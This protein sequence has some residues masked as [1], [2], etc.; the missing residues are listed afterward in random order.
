MADLSGTE[1]GGCRLIR[2]IGI[3]GMGEVYLGEQMR[4]GNRP[5][6]IK[7]VR[8]DDPTLTAD[9]IKEIERRFTREAALLGSF[10][11]PNILPV[12]DAG[13][14][15]RLLYLVMDYVEDGSLA[16][17]IRPGP[18]QKLAP[19]VPAPLTAE[20]IGQVAA[21]LQYTHDRGVVH[22]DVKP[23]NI[24]A[25]R[26]SD[27][28]WQL[29]LA[30]FGIAKAMQ[31]A[32]QK[33]QVTGTLTYMAP[34]QFSGQFSPASDQY[35][36]G[37]VAY[38]LLAGRPPFE[39]DLA[40]MTQAHLNQ[41]PPP[42]SRFNPGISP[43]VEAVVM[44]ALAKSPAQRFSRVADFA[45]ALRDA[46]TMPA[47]VAVGGTADAVRD[48]IGAE[49]RRPGLAR[50]WMAVLAALLLLAGGLGGAGVLLD[51]NQQVSAQAPQT[52][53][54]GGNT[55]VTAPTGQGNGTATDQAAGTATAVAILATQT[56]AAYFPTA[57]ATAGLG[58]DV[59]SPP[60]APAAAG[61]LLFA[62]IAPR[63]HGDTPA[64]IVDDNTSIAC[65][66]SGG[67]AVQAKSSGALACI[68]QR[69]PSIPADAFI[70]V[71]VT[72][73]SGDTTKGPVL[74]FRQGQVATGTPT[75]GVVSF[76]GT[77]Y[78]YSLNR[79]SG[80]YQLYQFDSATHQT[81]LATGGLPQ[82]TA[83]D[84]ALGVLVK[85]DQ[86][87]LYVNGHPIG[88]PITD[89]THPQGWASLCTTGDSVFRDFQ[90]YGLK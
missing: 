27:G 66:T 21:A 32:S 15:D 60:P 45:Q 51:H 41:P 67:V 13:V 72:Q 28:K 74:A 2:P 87:T 4:L 37:V 68:E 62:D 6:A 77:G 7:V 58:T 18:A 79:T 76:A 85:G 35:A 53:R 90:V 36:L 50:A 38:Q 88:S 34:E 19:P 64:W 25:R 81:T 59:T 57:T 61:A 56:A 31:D 23:G 63:C 71:L 40:T 65:P 3:G 5:V 52:A 89:T 22:R 55:T 80:E 82:A 29:L 30:D 8:L 43:A 44:R 20:L 73:S 47:G 54:A 14:Q 17:A 39:G 49:K 69:S 46:A 1:L 75:P 42:M 24:L 78:F 70:S 12:H 10:A 11:H 84:F 26:T 16:D 33:T 83:V 48:L 9:A 86:I